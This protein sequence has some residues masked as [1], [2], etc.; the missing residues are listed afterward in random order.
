MTLPPNPHGAHRA[1]PAR[2][3]HRPQLARVAEPRFLACQPTEKPAVGERRSQHAGASPVLNSH[4][5]RRQDPLVSVRRHARMGQRSGMSPDAT[6]AKPSETL[7]TS[8]VGWRSGS[9]DPPRP[10]PA[11]RAHGASVVVR[12]GDASMGFSA[13]ALTYAKADARARPQRWCRGRGPPPRSRVC[14]RA[15]HW[16]CGS[17][18]SRS[19]RRF[20]RACPQLR[21]SDIKTSGI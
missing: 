12:R 17:S 3:P 15:S 18:P 16:D 2:R 13:C 20:G 1:R 11:L 8:S 21:A 7:S 14:A 5:S 6:A 4:R 9:S 10:L 19:F